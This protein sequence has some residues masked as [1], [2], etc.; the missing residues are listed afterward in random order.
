[1]PS[2]LREITLKQRIDFQN[3]HGNIL[4]E[5]LKSIL[6]IKDDNDRELELLQ[7]QFEKMYRTFAFFAGTTPEAVKESEHLDHIANIYFSCLQ[8]LTEQENE[9]TLEHEFVWNSE[10]WLLQAPELKNGD[11]MTFGELIDSKQIVQDMMR[12]GKSQWEAMLPLCAIY[13][14]KK[15][16]V[17][18]E[19]FLYDDSDRL[20]LME[21]LPMDIALQVGFFLSSSLNMYRNISLSSSHPELSQ[22]EKQLRNILRTSVGS[23]FLSRSRKRRSSTSA[24]S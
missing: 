12:L 7:F 19:N 2:S 6:E 11:K 22:A 3:E 14:R 17:Y 21:S 15:D 18:Q 4:D 24:P 13:L 16:E 20:K 8:V 10:E 5:M 9:L 23:T 1:M